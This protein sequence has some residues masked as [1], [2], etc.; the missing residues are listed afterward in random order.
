MNQMMRACC[1]ISALLISVALVR[2]DDFK[3]LQGKEY[4][5]ATVSRVERD[6]IVLITPSG[7][8]KVNFTELPKDTQERFNYDPTKIERER[9]EMMQQRAIKA[10]AAE[11]ILAQCD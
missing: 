9:A 2:S 11:A 4:K 5:D 6:G 10:R 3:T 7:I 1:L 8:A